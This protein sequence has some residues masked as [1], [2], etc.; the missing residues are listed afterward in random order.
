MAKSRQ[1][2]SHLVYL[3]VCLESKNRVNYSL[4]VDLEHRVG[5]F[6]LGAVFLAKSLLQIVVL[7]QDALCFLFRDRVHGR[8]A[9]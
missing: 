5:S 8:A 6:E 2:A 3:L 7:E 9:A 4:D 1:P